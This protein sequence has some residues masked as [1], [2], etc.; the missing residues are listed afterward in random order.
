MACFKF[1]L[2]WQGLIHDWSKF[3]P[4]E[5]F[6]YANFFYGSGKERSFDVAWLLHQKRNP[7]H[8]Q[9]WILR[10][11][12]GN[13]KYIEMP[14]KYIWEMIADW[15]GAG[16]AQRGGPDTWDETRL[17]YN[18]NKKSIRL[19]PNTRTFIEGFLCV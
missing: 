6:P 14:D 2:Y 13:V 10:E 16:R 4:S 17:W 18:K 5:F 3:L 8:W 11:D 15:K 7:H 12:S 19:N 1:G 9:Y